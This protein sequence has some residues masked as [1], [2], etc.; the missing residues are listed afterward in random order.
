[1]FICTNCSASFPKWSGKCLN[2]GLWNTLEESKV[3]TKKSKIGS[4]KIL[5]T[6]KIMLSDESIGIQKY[7]SASS[8]LDMVLGGGL[9]SGSLVLLS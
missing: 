3:E 5:D 7:K 6:H 9:S 1:M 8:E 2:C 4:G